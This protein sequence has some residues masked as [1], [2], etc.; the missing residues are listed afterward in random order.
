MTTTLLTLTSPAGADALTPVRLRAFEQISALFR[1]EIDA[2]G[3]TV[4]IA[5]ATLLNKQAVLALSWGG[6]VVRYFSGIVCEFGATGPAGPLETPYRLVLA[7]QLIEADIAS[8]CR[9]FFNKSASD[10][11]QTLF[12]EAGVTKVDMRILSPAQSRPATAQYN[13][14]PLRLA[15]RLM[16]EEG[17]FYYFEHGESGETL[18]VA[19]ANSG[20]DAVEATL[21]FGSL[22]TPE[23]LTGWRTPSALAAGQVSVSDYDPTAPGKDLTKDKA[24]V[25]TTPGG[26]TRPVFVW[27]ALTDSPSV[28]GDRA[29]RRMEAEEALVALV[30][31]SG[32]CA[33][34][35]AGA[36]FTYLDASGKGTPFVVRSITHEAT[37]DTRRS[38]SGSES[39][40]NRF[41]AW[42]NA[43][44]WRERMA[45]ARPRME[46]LH[47]AVVLAPSGQ[48]IHTDDAGRVKVRFRWD[49]RA[50]AT[51]DT[52]PFIRVIQPWAGNGWGAQFI[53]RVNTEVAIA[54]MDADPDRP[55]VVGG[56]YNGANTPIFAAADKTKLGLRSRSSLS[57][58][59]DAFNEFSF[60]DKTGSEMVLL[61]AQKDFTTEVEHDQTIT[62]DNDRTETVKGKEAVTVT[63]DRTHKISQ[64]NESLTVA[65]GN[66]S[67][68]VTT[69]N[70]ATTIKT[71]NQTI[72]ID[73]GN[74]TTTLKMGDHL[75]TL[76]MGNST[77]EA[78]LG[79]ISI[80]ADVG[81]ITLEGLQGVT[82][83]CGAN[84]VEVTPE[85]VAIKG[86]MVS[87]EGQTMTTVKGLMLQAQ[88]EAMLTLKGAITMIN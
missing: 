74:Q 83:K 86:M 21:S 81:S 12:G 53:P 36:R 9:M 56:L 27:P 46:G 68:E 29:Q 14:T 6:S 84:S 82:L 26:S 80:K 47:T 34:L 16:E 22:D 59:T 18:V 32:S 45:T 7:P 58:G 52:A 38:G 66:R 51:A 69:G 63:G 23:L 20:F 40:S 76:T 55:V 67:V 24:T 8:D 64:G 11:L 78:K 61:H 30:A 19:D 39:Y 87:V 65:Q 41:S 48:E 37:D 44:P 35:F 79:N 5:P 3:G 57:G 71:G 49:W 54:F 1:F 10:I 73:T 88:G 72:E 75:L 13:E 31:G 15:T 4:P 43:T 25:L 62:V 77:T 2:I 60:D 85:G 17:W 70:D 33:S 28:S 50:D 42:P